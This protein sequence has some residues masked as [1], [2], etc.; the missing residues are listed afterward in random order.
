MGV[1]FLP[2][3]LLFKMGQI[4]LFISFN[5]A[6]FTSNSLVKVCDNE[7]YFFLVMVEG[8]LSFL[9]FFVEKKTI[10]QCVKKRSGY[11]SFRFTIPLIYWVSLPFKN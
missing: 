7:S 5:S 10:F 6:L 4:K 1:W 3:V 9:I 8:A 2:L 11:V